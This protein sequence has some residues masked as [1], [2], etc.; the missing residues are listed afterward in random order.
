MQRKVNISQYQKVTNEDLNNMGL[1]P[2]A[3]IDD[4]NRDIGTDENR[5]AGF[6]ITQ[7]SSS[8]LTVGAGRFHKNGEVYANTDNGG[9]TVS[10]LSSLPVVA[11]RVA[12]IVAWGT[13]NDTDTESRQYV[14]DVNTMQTE[15]RE[16]ATE[17]RRVANI[18]AE[19]GV[20]NATPSDPAI[21]ADYVAIARVIL[22]PAGIESYEMIEA[23]RVRSAKS[24][25]EE[26]DVINERLDAIGPELDNAKSN[27]ASI[28]DGMRLKAD[29]KFVTDLAFDVANVKETVGLPANYTAWGAEHF[30]DATGVD[31]AFSGYDALVR[32]GLHYSHVASA[33]QAIT[34]ANAL[35]ASVVVNDNIALPSFTSVLRLSVT[36]RDGEYALADTTVETKVLKHRQRCR[37]R[38][39]WH[40]TKKVGTCGRWWGSG[41]YDPYKDVFF[42][43]GETWVVVDAVDRTKS[44]NNIIKKL[45]AGTIHRHC[46][47]HMEDHWHDRILVSTNINGSIA[48]QT[49][50]QA[51]DGYLTKIGLFFTRRANAGDVRVSIC[52]TLTSGEPDLDKVVASTVLLQSS[53]TANINGTV[54]TQVTFT[55]TP[56]TK[57]K[58]YAVVLISTGAH[59]VA[60]V[61]GNK[62]ATGSLY[63]WNDGVPVQAAADR[64]LT[65]KQ[66]FAEF[67]NPIVQV[68]LEALQ[69]AG[70]IDMVDI[71]ADV[72]E[73][74]G[75]SIEFQMRDGDA[76]W[77][78]IGA[79]ETLLTSRPALVQ[80]RAVFIGTKD[81]MPALGLGST[82]SNVELS[83]AKTTRTA[84][85]TVK[86]MPSAINSVVVRVRYENWD[87]AHNASTVTVL[88]GAGHTTV[89]TADSTTTKVAPDDSTAVI[90]EYT[91][92]LASSRTDFR[93][94]EVGT[95]DSNLYCDHVA[96]IA[97]VAFA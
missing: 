3:S 37:H 48:G 56:L 47:R 91:F 6:A 45:L 77:K 80:F 49:F 54:E 78:T 17:S 53:I 25:G 26:V 67:T 51:A 75:T 21:Q 65:M 35:D 15:A 92:N 59:F 27:I 88:V 50:L 72:T 63:Y 39:R 73:F 81:I 14:T 32:E 33:S 23:N 95:T 24:I 20:E 83:R 40:R 38:V 16:T 7:S 79:E 44:V 74:E 2:R 42:R 36:G 11:K 90:K 69:L 19:Y 71:N 34:L 9:V 1:F 68:Q 55:P 4:L 70:G 13:T 62:L 61:S 96:E 10:M 93:I 97:Y 58:R 57:G 85:T 60:T 89:E 87:N 86:T 66:Y 76:I 64:D 5:F 29:L 52:E 43:T 22:T 31:A 8:S 84:I 94:K 30:L 46:R 28:A 41:R 18:G 12:I 82:R